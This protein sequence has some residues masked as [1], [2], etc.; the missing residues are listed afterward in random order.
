MQ[1]H[2]QLRAQML[3]VEIGTLLAAVLELERAF[4]SLRHVPEGAEAPVSSSEYL[5]AYS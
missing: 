1:R 5:R 3:G 4:A 2:L